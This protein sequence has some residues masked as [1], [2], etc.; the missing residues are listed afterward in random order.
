[1][2]ISVRW[3]ALCVRVAI[4]MVAACCFFR[5]GLPMQA[6]QLS[7]IAGVLA[8]VAGTLLGFLITAVTLLTAVM[9]RQLLVN[10]RKTGHYQRLVSE[11]FHTCIMLLAVLLVAVISLFLNEQ[12]IQLAFVLL[13]FFMT[14]SCF[15]LI[16]AGRRFS[17]V[18]LVMS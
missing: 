14:L 9:D 17:S 7:D 13:A 15:Y 2:T 18:I 16:E 12:A 3:K 1:M 6:D 5:Y 11:T 8:G 4:S 10:M